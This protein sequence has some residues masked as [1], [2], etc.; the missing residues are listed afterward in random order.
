MARAVDI[1]FYKAKR[2]KDCRKAYLQAN[3]LCERCLAKVPAEY[4]AS[5]YVHHVTELNADNVNDPKIA[6]GFDNLQALCFSCHEE[7]H[8][9]KVKR[10]YKVE[11]DGSI[12]IC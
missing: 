10:R 4:N 11:P 1:S 12:T 6:Y 2:W 3:P 9:R 7:I 5:K 8:E